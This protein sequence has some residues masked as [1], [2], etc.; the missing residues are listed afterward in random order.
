[1][2][3]FHEHEVAA[4]TA[5]VLWTEANVGPKSA[6]RRGHHFDALQ[7]TRPSSMAVMGIEG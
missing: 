4:I 6:E 2:E 5:V 7:P 3:L 1:L